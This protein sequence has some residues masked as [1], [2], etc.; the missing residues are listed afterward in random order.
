MSPEQLAAALGCPLERAAKW[1]PALDAAMAA[2]AI[3]SPARRAAFLAQIGHES[4]CLQYVREL[5]GPTPAQ[6]GYE[7]RIDLGNTQKGDGFRFR[8]RGLI[9]I[10]GRENYRTCGAALGLDLERQPELLEQRRYAA[11]SAGWYWYIHGLNALADH[12]AFDAITRAINGGFN[13]RD[14]RLALWVSAKDAL[15]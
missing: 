15:A 7:G 4:G 14:E 9:Q 8:G 12:E 1:L 5:W 3:D 6:A 13:G 2:Y 11:L 10:T